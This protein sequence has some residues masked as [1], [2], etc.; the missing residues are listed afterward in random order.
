MA[1]FMSMSLF[2]PGPSVPMATFTPAPITF[3]RSFTPMASF[4]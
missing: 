4:I 2:D 1:A 3:E